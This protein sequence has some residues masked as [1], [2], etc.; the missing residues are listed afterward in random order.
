MADP[1]QTSTSAIPAFDDGSYDSSLST[2]A[3]S[4][5]ASAIDRT[6]T[7]TQSAASDTGITDV[8]TLDPSASLSGNYTD[9]DDALAEGYPDSSDSAGSK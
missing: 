6:L 7:Q 8:D 5:L 2:S 1:T 9:Y 4:A 3:T